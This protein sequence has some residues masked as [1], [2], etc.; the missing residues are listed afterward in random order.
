M[1]DEKRARREA[2]VATFA[3][4][5][6]VAREAQGL[7]QAELSRQTSLPQAQ[8]S[9]M[10]S[11][12][13]VPRALTLVKLATSLN[14]S[15]DYL[16]GL[17]DDPKWSD[18]KEKAMMHRSV[19]QI[20]PR[21][22]PLV[23]GILR[24]FLQRKLLAVAFALILASAPASAHI[25]DHCS[26]DELAQA[27]KEKGE[28]AQELRRAVQRQDPAAIYQSFIEFIQADAQQE[29]VAEQWMECV[30]G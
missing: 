24:V 11:G 16:L 6:K 30:E 8:I 15:T 3:Q 21:N 20:E 2:L 27:Q 26:T 4:R 12:T 9:R 29:M 7:N 13:A 23:Q 25:P 14:V 22:L 5:L 28:V 19:E 17:R 18:S 1:T 10:E